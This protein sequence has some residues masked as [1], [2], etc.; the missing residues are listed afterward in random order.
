MWATEG[1]SLATLG[2]WHDIRR[3]DCVTLN[4]GGLGTSSLGCQLDYI[5]N[6]L[7]SKQLGTP[8]RVV[9]VV[10]LIKSFEV[11]GPT[12]NLDLLRWKDPPLTWA[13]P[14]AGSLYN[15]TLNKEACFL[16]SLLALTLTSKSIS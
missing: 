11:R 3:Y 14:S 7:K 5:W 1:D 10:F 4:R 2:F 12:F 6:Q 9:V 13:T 16:F 8:V 15:R